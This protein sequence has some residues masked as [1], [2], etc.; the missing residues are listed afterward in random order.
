[1]IKLAVF[2]LDGTLINTI[3]DLADSINAILSLKGFETHDVE[4][5]YY[6]VGH[7]FSDLVYRALPCDKRDDKELH[8]ECLALCKA[9]YEEHYLDK[10]RVYDGIN[11]L[12]SGLKEKGIKTAVLTNKYHKMA[13]ALI[14]KLFVKGTFDVVWGQTDTYP[15]KPDPTLLLKVISDFDTK[16][17]NCFMIGDS[18]MDMAVAVNAGCKGVGVLWGFRDEKELRE[19]GADYIVSKPTDILDISE[20]IK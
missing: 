15:V 11:E 18:G 19:N 12:I 2:D 9:Y 6:L 7:G 1:M 10:S 20:E 3:D 8:S 13:N 4:T 14:N 5:Y 17:E 16:P